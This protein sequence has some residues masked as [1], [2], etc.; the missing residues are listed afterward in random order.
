MVC[1]HPVEL[2]V[3]ISLISTPFY[4][5]HHNILFVSFYSV[6]Y[7]TKLLLSPK[8]PAEL[9]DLFH[10]GILYHLIC[11]WLESGINKSSLCCSL[12]L[13]SVHILY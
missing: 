5:S 3:S 12:V 6:E 10:C 8:H 7:F 4:K 2:L 13:V 1:E 11:F 9:S